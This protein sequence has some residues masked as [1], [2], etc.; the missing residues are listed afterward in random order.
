[1]KSLLEALQEGRL[2]ELPVNEKEK[3]F[4]LLALLI[5]AIPDWETVWP[6]LT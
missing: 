3:V 6:F 2:I 4:E 1:M 5:E